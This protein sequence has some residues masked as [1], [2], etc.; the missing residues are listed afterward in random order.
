M[1]QGDGNRI[2]LLEGKQLAHINITILNN[3]IPED[4]KYFEVELLNPTGGAAIGAASILR[5]LIQH[6]DDAFGLFGFSNNSRRVFV[7]E[8]IGSV[9]TFQL[10]R[11]EGLLREVGTIFRP[12]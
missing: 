5:I 8:S 12:I 2:E 7:N 9:A 6:S 11:A 10:T 1:F 3:H 4:D